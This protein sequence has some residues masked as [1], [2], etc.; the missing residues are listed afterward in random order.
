MET[1]PT[2]LDSEFIY[3]TSTSMELE[4]ANRQK[5]FRPSVCNE[6]FKTLSQNLQQNSVQAGHA[7]S[8][9]TIN[10]NKGIIVEDVCMDDFAGCTV[11]SDHLTSYQTDA[12]E[13]SEKFSLYNNPDNDTNATTS[14]TVSFADVS[15]A[16]HTINRAAFVCLSVCLSVCLFPISSEVLYRQTWWVYVGGPRILKRSNVTF[17]DYIIYAPASCHTSSSCFQ[18]QSLIRH[19]LLDGYRTA[20][21]QCI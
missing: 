14:L 7:P 1:F 19:L 6:H 9:I 11:T 16:H 2:C 4:L 12:I 13:I 15:P 20:S 18:L 8:G 3:R 17:I 5:A 10:Q 21:Q